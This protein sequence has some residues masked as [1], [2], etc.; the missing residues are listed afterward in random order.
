MLNHRP[1]NAHL[2]SPD[3]ETSA[4]VPSVAAQFGHWYDP[5][6]AAKSSSAGGSD[7]ARIARRAAPAVAVGPPRRDMT[8]IVPPT[9][10]NTTPIRLPNTR[11]NGGGEPNSSNGAPHRNAITVTPIAANAK[12]T[13][14]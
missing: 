1:Q 4:F 2:A 9:A 5:P 14:A 6:R 7:G 10:T 11:K 3:G 13:T 8:P 12:P